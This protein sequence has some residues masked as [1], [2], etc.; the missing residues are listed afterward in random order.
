[1]KKT[2]TKPYWKMNTREL[3][4]ATREYDDP[5]RRPKFL[6]EPRDLKACHDG[7]LGDIRRQRAKAKG[8]VKRLQLTMEPDLLNR[9]DACARRLGLTRTQFITRGVEAMLAKAG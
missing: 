9:T 2:P 8:G 5:E 1:M 3:A 4:D 7:I 6:P